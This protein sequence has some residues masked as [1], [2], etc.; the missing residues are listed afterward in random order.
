[1]HHW[2]VLVN[3]IIIGRSKARQLESS[4]AM[5]R[6]TKMCDRYPIRQTSGFQITDT[7]AFVN[8]LLQNAGRY[9][10]LTGANENA[11]AKL[12]QDYCDAAPTSYSATTCSSRSVPDP[13]PTA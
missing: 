1:M 4:S 13:G 11:C 3:R 2:M 7:E 9:A 12:D 6:F 5:I 10:F 8:D